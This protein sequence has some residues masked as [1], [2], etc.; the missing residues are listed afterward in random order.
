MIEAQQEAA[1]NAEA[2]EKAG[3]EMLGV[4]RSDWKNQRKAI[5]DLLKELASGVISE[6]RA[7][8]DL[9][10]IGVPPAKIDLYIKDAADGSVDNLEEITNG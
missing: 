1:A 2:P 3:S 4:R 7:R 6:Q 10:S 5:N 9:D 8:L